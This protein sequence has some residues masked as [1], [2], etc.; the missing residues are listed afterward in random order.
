MS[1]NC[2]CYRLRCKFLTNRK[3]TRGVLNK[4]SW[5]KDWNQAHYEIWC[6]RNSSLMLVKFDL[7][8]IN[9]CEK[10]K[11]WIRTH[12]MQSMLRWK[13]LKI[14]AWIW[15]KKIFDRRCD[16]IIWHRICKNWKTKL[17]GCAERGMKRI[18]PYVYSESSFSNMGAGNIALKIGAQGVCTGQLLVLL[19]MMQLVKLSVKLNLVFMMLLLAGGAEASITK[20][21]IAGFQFFTALFNNGRPRT[22]IHSIWQRPYGFVMGKVQFANESLEHAL[23][24]WC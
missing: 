21:G 16:C 8:S 1:T 10:I 22:F 3:Y 4:P 9:I 23:K 5:R 14:Q 6:F 24:T 19:P 12:C 20:I 17:S 13:L 11:S 7:S 18:Q 15:K 2:C